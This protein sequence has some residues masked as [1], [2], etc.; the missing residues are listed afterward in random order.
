MNKI[1]SLGGLGA[2]EFILLAGITII[3]GFIYIV[4]KA[5]RKGYSGDK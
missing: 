1:A 2:P 5:F 4:V 3:G